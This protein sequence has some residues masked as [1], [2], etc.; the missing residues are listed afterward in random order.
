[1]LANTSRRALVLT[2]ESAR[3]PFRITLPPHVCAT[4]VRDSLLRSL[5]EA[6]QRDWRSVAT[7]YC[8]TFCAVTL[9]MA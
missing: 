1:M 5:K 8:A 6:F 2:D 4:P 9:F 3:H 7:T